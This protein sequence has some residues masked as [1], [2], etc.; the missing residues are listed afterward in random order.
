MGIIKF[1]ID[2]YFVTSNSHTKENKLPQM[3]IVTLIKKTFIRCYF[4]YFQCHYSEPINHKKG[5]GEEIIQQC[6]TSPN[7][8]IVNTKLM[9]RESDKNK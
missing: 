9:I 4:S 5:G 7:I 3:I 8:P 1:A 6:K 2:L